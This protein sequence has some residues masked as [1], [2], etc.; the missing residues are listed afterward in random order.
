MITMLLVVAAASISSPNYPR[1]SPVSQDHINRMAERIESS[2]SLNDEIDQISQ[3]SQYW[4]DSCIVARVKANSEVTM[5]ITRLLDRP[6]SRLVAARM[7]FDIGRSLRRAIPKLT[8]VLDQA[9]EEERQ[10]SESPA[11]RRGNV[12]SESLRCVLRKARTGGI[13]RD[14]CRH[15]LRMRINDSSSREMI[16]SP[17]AASSR[18]SC[19]RK[20]AEF[21]IVSFAIPGAIPGTRQ[22]R[23]HA[24]PGTLYRSASTLCGC[25][26]SGDTALVPAIPGTLYRSASTLC[27]CAGSGDT[28]LVPGTLYRIASTQGVPGTRYRIASTQ[29]RSV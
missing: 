6:S 23:G 9:A 26:G 17:A 28:A 3:L 25:A 2:A 14:L 7:L 5:A 11:L 4:R 8:Q 29:V 12:L 1:C 21:G 18:T 24:I 10:R 27:G 20:G 22:F 13:H 19:G 15:L 16:P